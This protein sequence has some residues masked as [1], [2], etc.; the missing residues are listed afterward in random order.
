[1]LGEYPEGGCTYL[2]P[3][4]DE[5][6]IEKLGLPNTVKVSGYLELKFPI[7][8]HQDQRV[9]YEDGYRPSD[10]DE[11]SSTRKYVDIKNFKGNNS[12]LTDLQ[13]VD[14]ELERIIKKDMPSDSPNI[15]AGRNT[16]HTGGFAGLFTTTMSDTGGTFSGGPD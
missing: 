1:M 11:S 15:K 13:N 9:S 2:C 5:S 3:I 4:V 14:P 7:T 12:F 10:T 8:S 6:L 16:S